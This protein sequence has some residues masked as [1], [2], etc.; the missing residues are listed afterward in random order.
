MDLL[1]QPVN[2][3]APDVVV[4]VVGRRWILEHHLRRHQRKVDLPGG[5]PFG[6]AAGALPG[7]DECA[8]ALVK[9]HQQQPLRVHVVK[10]RRDQDAF[11][12]QAV[13]KRVD[14]ALGDPVAL[15]LQHPLGKSGGARGVLDVEQVVEP[16]RL[17]RA[18]GRIAVV[19]QRLPLPLSGARAA[20][21]NDMSVVERGRSL[22]HRI[23]GRQEFV[24]DHQE[25][26][27]AVVDDVVEF[28]RGVGDIHR[29]HH[30]TEASDC[31]PRQGKLRHVGHHH[32]HV[33]A[34]AH[35]DA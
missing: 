12:G 13:A 15:R 31:Q 9:R 29:H 33:G 8:R 3:D 35:A 18:K 22:G 2:V 25:L 17:G 28:A 10:G 19:V 26:R 21:D 16:D 4:A 34:L 5:E 6:V 20:D 30:R 32:R 1:A 24:R 23:Q 7:G 27:A 11:V 14:L